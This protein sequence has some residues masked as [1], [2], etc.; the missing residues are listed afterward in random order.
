METLPPLTLKL[1]IED[2]APVLVLVTEPRSTAPVPIVTVPPAIFTLLV[3]TGLFV[4]VALPVSNPIAR[5]VATV[6]VPVSKVKADA[7]VAFE[8]ADVFATASVLISR[9]AL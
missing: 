7:L 8:V 1:P 9:S 5:P 3:R 4:A 2:R 6:K